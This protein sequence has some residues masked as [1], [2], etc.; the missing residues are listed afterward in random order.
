MTNSKWRKDLTQNW[1]ICSF[2]L[3]SLCRGRPFR[4]VNLATNMYQFAICHALSA[5]VAKANVNRSSGFDELVPS[6]NDAKSMNRLGDRDVLDFV[7]LV[8][9]HPAEIA[10]FDQA[11]R[12]H[13]ETCP[14]DPIEWTG[15]SPAL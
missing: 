8:A 13:S 4:N 9:H 2:C 12:F 15:S 14:Q 1:E 7:M 3:S 11:H 6:I 5:S 10:F